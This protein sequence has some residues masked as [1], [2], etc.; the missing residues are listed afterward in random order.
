MQL[1]TRRTQAK[2]KLLG[3]LRLSSKFAHKQTTVKI[4]VSSSDEIRNN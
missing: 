4:Q 3:R 1:C 2:S